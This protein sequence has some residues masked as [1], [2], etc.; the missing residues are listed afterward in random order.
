MIS[1]DLPAVEVTW[2]DAVP[3]GGIQ[4]WEWGPCS[5]TFGQDYVI[6][7]V[8]PDSQEKSRGHRFV[9]DNSPHFFFRFRYFLRYHPPVHCRRLVRLVTQE[10]Q[11]EIV[12]ELQ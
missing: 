8:G 4:N 6:L 7:S 9:V 12:G 3:A 1:A 2:P 11:N 10:C 5:F